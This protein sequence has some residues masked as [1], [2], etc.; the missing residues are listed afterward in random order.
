M[1]LERLPEA[2]LLG[3]DGSPAML[4]EARRRLTRFGGRVRL[5]ECDFTEL[6][7]L[8]ID[9]VDAAFAE[10]VTLKRPPPPIGRCR[11]SW[12]AADAVTSVGRRAAGRRAGR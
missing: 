3:V 7:R 5:V 4:A 9:P 6:G 11:Q 1:V 2:T 10:Q 8:R 12:I